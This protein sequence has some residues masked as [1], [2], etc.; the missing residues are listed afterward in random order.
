MLWYCVVLCFCFILCVFMLCC[1]MFC[2]VSCCVIVSFCFVLCSVYVV[3]F[4]C[5]FVVETQHNCWSMLCCSMLCC[6]KFWLGCALLLFYVLLGSFLFVVLWGFFVWCFIGC[7]VPCCV[8]KRFDIC[9]L[10]CVAIGYF[11]VMSRFVLCV[12]F[13]Y[14]YCM[15]YCCHDCKCSH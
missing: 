11:V 5:C 3:L 8:V 12:F 1:F 4:C 7:F 2:V 15:F 10:C 6:S 9:L 13:F 14:R